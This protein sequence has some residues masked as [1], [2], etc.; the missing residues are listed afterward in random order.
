MKEQKIDGVKY[1]GGKQASKLLGIH[2][3]TV[4]WR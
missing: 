4:V 2:Q 1:I 3:R